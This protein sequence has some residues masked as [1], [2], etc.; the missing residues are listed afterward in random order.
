MGK[1]AL[2]DEHC[3][4]PSECECMYGVETLLNLLLPILCDGKENERSD[5]GANCLVSFRRPLKHWK[6][7][8]FSYSS[9]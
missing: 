7:F 2:G 6:A 5:M 4:H 9:T 8:S 1:L 3:I